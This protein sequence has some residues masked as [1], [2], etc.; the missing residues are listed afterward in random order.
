MMLHRIRV[1][2]WYGVG[3]VSELRPVLLHDF[4]T[5]ES[6][7]LHPVIVRRLLALAPTSV[8]AGTGSHVVPLV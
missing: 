3:F 7:L 5:R 1:G 2:T 8:G 4:G 6:G